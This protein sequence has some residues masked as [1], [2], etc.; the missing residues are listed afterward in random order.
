MI[1]LLIKMNELLLISK[2][3]VLDECQKRKKNQTTLAYFDT[4]IIIVNNCFNKFSTWRNSFLINMNS[5]QV[6]ARACLGGSILMTETI[7]FWN[8]LAYL[9]WLFVTSMH[10]IMYKQLTDMNRH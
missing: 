9:A 5:L 2:N 7:T 3:G 1:I 10:L 4:A 8:T 6:F